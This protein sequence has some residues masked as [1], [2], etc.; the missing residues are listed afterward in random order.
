MNRTNY[1]IGIF[2]VV[3]SIFFA[4]LLLFRILHIN[5]QSIVSP[6]AETLPLANI[7]FFQSNSEKKSLQDIIDPVLKNT[8]GTYG[9][10]IRNLKTY[11][12]YA[13][14]DHRVFQSGSLYKLWV[15]GAVYEQ[16]KNGQLHGSDILQQEI[17][18]LNEKFR[19]ASEDA[20]LAEGVIRLSVDDAME[21]MI[22][23]SDN[24]A[25]LLLSEKVRLSRVQQFLSVKGFGESK[26]G[27]DGNMPTTTP[28]D[29]SKFFTMIYEGKLLNKEYDIKMLDLLKQQ[30][31][32][33]KIPKKL[34]KGTVIAH[35]TG[36][37]GLFTHDAG[38]VYMKN[39]DYIIVIFSESQTPQ[40]E[41]QTIA[42]LSEAV[43][44][45][46]TE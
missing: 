31:L 19:I 11:E 22:T 46:F 37:L 40:E 42:D 44:R 7:P 15:M 6:T 30:K 3:L 38:I 34:P 24:Y 14:N 17:P 9:I 1:Q 10:I 18:L 4:S 29:I 36:E 13:L 23:V 16:I 45:Y 35:K 2:L 20:E 39:G 12:T 8:K 25:A 33:N 43:Y 28:S 5:P 32:N 27:T 26:V 41:E 21:Q